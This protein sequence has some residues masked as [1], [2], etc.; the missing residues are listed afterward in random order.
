MK[1]E[2]VG[3]RL[4]AQTILEHERRLPATG[5][6]LVAVGDTVRSD[7]IVAR[8]ATP[9]SLRIVDAAA[10]LGL[11]RDDLP[12]SLRVAVGQEVEADAVLAAAGFMGWRTVRAPAAGRIAQ[13]A[14]GRIFIQE[15]P[16]TVEL[17]AHLPGQVIRLAPEWGATIRATVARAVGLWGA[18]GE[19]YGPLLLRTETPAATLN[20]I[21]IDLACRGRIVVGGQCLDKRVLLRAARFRALGL[22]VGGLAEHLRPRVRELGLP[23]LVTDALAAM[24][25]APPI[26]EL[27]ARHDGH[28]AL[29]NAGTEES[30]GRPAISIPLP[31][32]RGPV[33]VAP[34]RPL[35]VGDQV[36][37]I[38]PPHLG[39][40][41]WV[42]SI[43][44]QES[45]AWVQV[46]LE[47]GDLVTIAYRNLER[48][49]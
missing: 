35:A 12:R 20:W 26:Y 28:E 24:P 11:A 4:F 17:R 48:L 8:C 19:C 16:R 46:R 38:R 2:P 13:I 34:E 30:T 21:G 15:P 22:V 25:M 6:V 43:V 47:G 41:G 7:D 39:A 37:L 29:L 44:E 5:T 3:S 33:N 36:R 45:E 42:H 23:V 27:L 18:G 1:A 49:A 31:S 40:T 10:A 14:A 32:L 9:G